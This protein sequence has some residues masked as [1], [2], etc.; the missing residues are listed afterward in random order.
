MVSDQLTPQEQQRIVDCVNACQG[1]GNPAGIR[2][3]LEAV[4]GLLVAWNE[5]QSIARDDAEAQ[6]LRAAV[7]NLDPQ[8][9]TDEERN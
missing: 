5:G 7:L 4:D 9:M 2:E 3:L 6:Q 1:L 8:S